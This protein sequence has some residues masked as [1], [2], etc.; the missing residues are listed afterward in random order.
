MT[1]PERT[2]FSMLEAGYEFPPASYIL[3]PELISSY[4]TATSDTYEGYTEGKLVPPTAVAA[5]A[6][7]ALANEMEIPPGTIHTSQEIASIAPVRI[8]DTITIHARVG[9]K[10]S[11][12][13][14]EMMSIDIDVTNQHNN[15]VLTGKT[16]FMSSPQFSM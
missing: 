1:N 16:A 2:Q 7:A 5:Y 10:R 14:M 12:K 13:N 3:E 15:T 9:S 6:L 11:R 4:I 8:N